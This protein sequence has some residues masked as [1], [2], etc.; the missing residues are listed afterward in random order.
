MTEIYINIFFTE[1]NIQIQNLPSI[2]GSPA[3]TLN[4]RSVYSSERVPTSNLYL[5]DSNTNLFM[6]PRGAPEI[7]T[8]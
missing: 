4:Y 3:A 6:S 1:R 7:K 8:D 5:S 2:F